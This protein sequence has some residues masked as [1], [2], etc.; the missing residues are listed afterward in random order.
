VA[1][2]ISRMSGLLLLATTLPSGVRTFLSSRIMGAATTLPALTGNIL[3]ERVFMFNC[4]V[5]LLA[6]PRFM[7]LRSQELVEERAYSRLPTVLFRLGVR[8]RRERYVCGSESLRTSSNTSS[9]GRPRP[10]AG[11]HMSI[12]CS[13][14]LLTPTSK[15]LLLRVN[16]QTGMR[17]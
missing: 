11:C 5:H 17:L 12:Q 15:H 7:V 8:A 4:F 2:S 10:E 1:L 3:Q 16:V 9:G 13:P 14:T 6:V